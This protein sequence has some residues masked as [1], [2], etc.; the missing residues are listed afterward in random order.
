MDSWVLALKRTGSYIPIKELKEEHKAWGMSL[1]RKLPVVTE[2]KRQHAPH[3]EAGS[4]GQFLLKLYGMEKVK[5]FYRK[6]MGEKRPWQDIFGTDLALL[7][8]EGL[9]SLNEYGR[10]PPGQID[11]LTTL[12][13]QNPR[14]ARSGHRGLRGGLRA[15]FGV[16]LSVVELSGSL[17]Y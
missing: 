4:F 5:A 7:K 16:F 6:S 12:W 15:D 3:I 2:R 9:K 8:E 1:N 10:T 11:F 17:G 13:K 14:G